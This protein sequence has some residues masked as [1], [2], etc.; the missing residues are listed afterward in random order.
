MRTSG[1]VVAADAGAADALAADRHLVG[2]R[3]VTLPQAL[4][5]LLRRHARVLHPI[6][7]EAQPVQLQ[8]RRHG[9]AVEEYDAGHVSC[10]IASRLPTGLAR[11]GTRSRDCCSARS[12]QAALVEA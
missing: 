7:L 4:N 10:A 12:F 3:D 6:V 1:S 8:R 2:D 11:S 5:N 9:A